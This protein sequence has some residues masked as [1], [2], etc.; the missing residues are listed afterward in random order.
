LCFWHFSDNVDTQQAVFQFG[1]SYGHVI[2]E[3][4][5]QSEIVSGDA[6]IKVVNASSLFLLPGDV[7]EVI[8]EAYGKLTFVEAWYGDCDSIA[9]VFYTHDIMW[10]KIVPGVVAAK[11]LE[12]VIESIEPDRCRK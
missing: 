4:E 11:R 1:T 10:W 2:G 5:T 8:L 9:I 6:L 12:Q 7:Q 3:A